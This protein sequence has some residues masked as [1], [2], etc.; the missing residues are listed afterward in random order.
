MVNKCYRHP[1]SVLSR[2]IR[3]YKI[4][5]PITLNIRFPHIFHT[6]HK[7]HTKVRCYKHSQM[8]YF[9]RDNYDDNIINDNFTQ[10]KIDKR[11]FL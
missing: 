3:T 10:K 2:N 4:C 11:C 6:K 7:N 1:V 5:C 8:Y 9:F